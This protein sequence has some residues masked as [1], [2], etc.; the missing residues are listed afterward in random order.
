MI[1]FLEPKKW[2]QQYPSYCLILL[3]DGSSW[4]LGKYCKDLGGGDGIDEPY[5]FHRD[6]TE[7][8]VKDLEAAKKECADGCDANEDCEY[9]EILWMVEDDAKWCT[10]WKKGVC[11]MQD[12]DYNDS[13]VYKK[14]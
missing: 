1:I 9:A 8:P 3:G 7:K 10:F 2:H 11:E 14:Q 5:I 4:I 13:Y 12:N 6:Y